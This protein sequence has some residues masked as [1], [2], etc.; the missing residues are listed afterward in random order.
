MS[1]QP[2]EENWYSIDKRNWSI[3]ASGEPFH[4][5]NPLIRWIDDEFVPNYYSHTQQEPQNWQQIDFGE[6]LTVIMISVVVRV[7]VA[8]RLDNVQI[9][10]GNEDESSI[11]DELQMRYVL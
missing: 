10:V 4:P 9:R 2:G 7:V 3:K 6:E 5:S 1:I 11:P 8:D